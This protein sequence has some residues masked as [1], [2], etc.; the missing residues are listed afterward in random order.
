MRQRPTHP[1]AKPSFGRQLR[2]GVAVACVLAGLTS[3]T[4]ASASTAPTI[5]TARRARSAR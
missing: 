2:H 5:P 3:A 4:T 1:T